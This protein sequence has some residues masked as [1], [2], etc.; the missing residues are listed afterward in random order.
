MWRRIVTLL[1]CLLLFSPVAEAD[2]FKKSTD[3]GCFKKARKFPQGTCANGSGGNGGGALTNTTS[4][5][6]NDTGFNGRIEGPTDNAIHGATLNDFSGCLW[7]EVDTAMARFQG[8]A[9]SATSFALN[10]GYGIYR[11]TSDTVVEFYVGTFSSSYS[12]DYS[13]TDVWGTGNGWQHLCYS[14]DSTSRQY[15]VWHNAVQMQSLTNAS[16]ATRGDGDENHYGAVG[17][18]GTSGAHFEGKVDEPAF[19]T[20]TLSQSEV[21]D[22]YNSGTPVDPTSVKSGAEWWLRMG[23]DASD[24][25]TVITGQVTDQTANSNDFTP[26]GSDVNVN[27]VSDVP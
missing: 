3:T 10:D 16:P 9:G 18:G 19:W 4:T 15:T 27:F 23:D 14:H 6:F 24:V 25:E 5:D 12:A 21:D 8:P 22:L 20:S 2:T 17:T 13:P 7:Y 11:G 26:Q 1:S